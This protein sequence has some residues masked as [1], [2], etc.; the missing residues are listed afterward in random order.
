MLS[1]STNVYCRSKRRHER[2]SCDSRRARY[3]GRFA[4][5]F[6][7]WMGSLPRLVAQDALWI[8]L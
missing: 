3:R 7:H 6:R 2:I 1:A 4:I 8:K 5:A